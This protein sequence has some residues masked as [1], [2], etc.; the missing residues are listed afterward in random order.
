MLKVMIKCQWGK[1]KIWP[2]ILAGSNSE[3]IQDIT[4]KLTMDE[5][6]KEKLCKNRISS[7]S[8]RVMFFFFF[9]LI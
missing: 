2:K 9:V 4:L 3:A 6:L 8:M 1:P 7:K 5:C